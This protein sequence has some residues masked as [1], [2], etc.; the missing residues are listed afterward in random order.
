MKLRPSA[1]AQS[2]S[3]AGDPHLSTVTQVFTDTM[4]EGKACDEGWFLGSRESLG[5]PQ[6]LGEEG[7]MEGPVQLGSGFPKAKTQI[8]GSAKGCELSQQ[9]PSSLQ[10][11]RKY[12]G[13]LAFSKRGA[14][15]PPGCCARRSDEQ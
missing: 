10:V 12:V 2:A 5:T 1:I 11:H 9:S 6:A 4:R 8:V 7:Q 13:S 3:S 14:N 15:V